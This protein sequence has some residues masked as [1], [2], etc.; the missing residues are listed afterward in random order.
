MFVLAAQDIAGKTLGY[1]VSD[2]QDLTQD[3][4]QALTWET[5][6]AAQIDADINNKQW[7]LVF[8]QFVPVEA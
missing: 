1:Y 8:E 7:D 5:R 3:K 2:D 6:E 4:A